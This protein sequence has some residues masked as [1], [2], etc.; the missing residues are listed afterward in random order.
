MSTPWQRVGLSIVSDG[1]R[2]K[3]KGNV[4]A[5][6]QSGCWVSTHVPWHV[7][8]VHN[9]RNCEGQFKGRQLRHS[10]T[11]RPLVLSKLNLKE[12]FGMKNNCIEGKAL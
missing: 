12:V 3:A 8:N 10:L 9:C 4:Q 5:W 1:Y 11:E 2:Q 6:L 7:F